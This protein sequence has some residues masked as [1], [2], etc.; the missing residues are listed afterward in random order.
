MRTRTTDHPA[1]AMLRAAVLAFLLVGTWLVLA[2]FRPDHRDPPA[3]RAALRGRP[4]G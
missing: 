4:A 3:A 1:A 2:R